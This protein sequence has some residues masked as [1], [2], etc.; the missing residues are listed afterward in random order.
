MKLFINLNFIKMETIRNFQTY[1][2][3]VQKYGNDFMK[4]YEY[5]SSTSVN[6]LKIKIVCN[7]LLKNY[8]HE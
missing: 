3:I 5:L 8:K 1:K 4:S 2:G 7:K 6:R